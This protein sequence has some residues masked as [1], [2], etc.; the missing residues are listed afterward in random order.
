M[1]LLRA[2]FTHGDGGSNTAS[3]ATTRSLTAD[4]YVDFS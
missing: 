1:H 3:I 2:Y 4:D